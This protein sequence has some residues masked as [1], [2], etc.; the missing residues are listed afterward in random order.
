MLC[1]PA[2]VVQEPVQV[3]PAQQEE[4]LY[5]GSPYEDGFSCKPEASF[6]YECNDCRCLPNGKVAMCTLKLCN[7]DNVRITRG[8]NNNNNPKDAN[9]RCTPGDQFTHSDGC[10]S[11]ICSTDGRT[12]ACT[13]RICLSNTPETSTVVPEVVGVVPAQEKKCVPGSRFMSDDGCKY[14]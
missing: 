10:N 11:C 9:F 3:V 13:L 1:V 5:T 4:P 14:M 7:A 12:A 8:V 6:K 2:P